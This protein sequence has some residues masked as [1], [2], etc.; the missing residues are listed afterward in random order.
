[1]VVDLWGV[2]AV[3]VFGAPPTNWG[4]FGRWLGN[5][6][7]GRFVHDSI[8]KAPAVRGELLLGWSGHYAIGIAFAAL[9][10]AICGLDWA[11]HPTPL[12]ALLFGLVKVAAPFF[13]MQPAM[14]AGIAAANTP[15]PGPARLRSI[16]NHAMFGVGL[17][18]SALLVA[19][20]G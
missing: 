12:P 2:L 8:A 5:F 18:V 16:A 17:Y 7:R 1:V 11:R 19:R 15:K 20:A 13:I 9:L 14:G 4:M 6:P 10:I 3:R